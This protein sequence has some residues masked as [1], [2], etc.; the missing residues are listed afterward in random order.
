MKILGK[1]AHVS[2]GSTSPCIAPVKPHVEHRVW[3]GGRGGEGAFLAGLTSKCRTIF[4]RR[5]MAGQ[6]IG[7]DD[8]RTIICMGM[9]RSKHKLDE[10]GVE[11]DKLMLLGCLCLST[12]FVPLYSSVYF[13][14]GNLDNFFPSHRLFGLFSGVSN[15]PFSPVGHLV[16]AACNLCY[17]PSWSHQCVLTPRERRDHL[18]WS[19]SLISCPTHQTYSK[20][21]THYPLLPSSLA[22]GCTHYPLHTNQT[23]F[24]LRTHRHL[25]L[26]HIL[27]AF[28]IIIVHIYSSQTGVGLIPPKV[29]VLPGCHSC[30]INWI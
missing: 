20:L 18:H 15:F 22:V 1:F 27:I 11:L 21:T 26:T 2:G 28:H 24:R 17:R 14:S 30:F 5:T 10:K 3:W 9:K 19:Q 16:G 25:I 29:P 13:S 23:Y 7:G 8:T 6:G 12:T 4:V